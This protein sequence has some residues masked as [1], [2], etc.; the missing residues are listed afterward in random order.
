M[1]SAF[2]PRLVNSV[3][4]DPCL[5][6]GLRWTGRAVLFDLGRLDRLPAPEVLRTR[7]VFVTHTHMDHFI[8]FD[9]LLR[10]FLARD[11]EV[12][13]FGP[14]GVIDNVLGKLRGYTW[15][16]VDGYPFVLTVHEVASDSIRAVRLRA[17][18]AFA[19]EPLP[20]RAFAGLLVDD[21][22]LRAYA[23]HLDHR[24]PSLGYAIQE[25]THLN[26][27]T[28]ELDRLGIPPGPWINAVKEGI[29]TAAD[30]DTAIEA[31]WR[32]EG[33]VETRTLR[34]GDLRDRLVA[35][36]P[37]QKLVYVTDTV[38]SHDNRRRI[39]ELAQGADVFFCE[40]LFVDADRDQASKRYHLT[41]RQAG[42][43]ARLAGV[44]RLETFHFS[45]RYDGDAERLQREAQ[46]TFA[47]DLPPDEP[48]V[49]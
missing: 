44:K 7:Y 1:K 19:P 47:G 3:F 16:L 43:M 14:P 12:D 31:R 45:P 29:R 27:R 9:H 25:E 40:S 21:G 15:N 28:D 10:L 37:G 38:F 13:L 24:I 8:G 49:A 35:V 36:T 26:V 18:G 22:G 6:V 30:D 34:L 23:T 48:D 17:T 11:A 33:K 46:A 5:F 4:G 2:Q 42:T 41:A 32:S 39:I 20:E